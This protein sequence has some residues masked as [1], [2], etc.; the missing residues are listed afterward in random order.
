MNC[1]FSVEFAVLVNGGPSEE[2]K[3]TRGLRQGDPLSSYLFLICAEGLFAL[4]DRDDSTSNLFY[5]RINNHCSIITHLFFADDSLIFCRAENEQCNK[6]KEVLHVYEKASGQTINLKKSSFMTSKNIS[7]GKIAE[8]KGILGIRHAKSLGQYLGMPSQNERNKRNL[9]AKVRDRVWKV[10]QGWKENLFSCGGKEVLIKSVAQAIPTYTM[11]CFKIPNNICEDIDS[12]CAKFWWG[13]A[14]K[15]RKIHWMSWKKLCL[16]KKR[17]DMGFRDI[18]AFNQAMLAKMSWRI[19]KNS[20]SLLFKTLR[21]RYFKD[22]DF[23]NAHSGSNPSLTWR[24]FFGDVRSLKKV[25]VGKLVTTTIL[26]LRK[27]LGLIDRGIKRPSLPPRAS[28]ARGLLTS[29]RK[30]IGGTREKS[31]II[32]ALWM[33]NTLSTFLWGRLIQWMRSS[34]PWRIRVY[35]RLKVLISLPLMMKK[36]ELPLLP[37]VLFMKEFG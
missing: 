24:G 20:D 36:V 2:F 12:L 16:N 6:I 29:N 28:K 31:S 26:T 8:L 25:I 9:F 5:F 13:A 4:L 21:G 34:G 11:S 17:G 7:N 37:T 19:L 14:G 1:I 33:L 18:S 27:I 15:K 3:P 10:L 30:E 35:S 22:G 23:L 32:F